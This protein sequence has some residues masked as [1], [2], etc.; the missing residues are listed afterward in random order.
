MKR[1][2][3]H[4]VMLYKYGNNRDILLDGRTI[5]Y[6]AKEIKVAREHVALVLDGQQLCTPTTAKKLVDRLKPGENIEDYFIESEV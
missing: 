1:V 6:V 3:E 5:A 2:V 4:R